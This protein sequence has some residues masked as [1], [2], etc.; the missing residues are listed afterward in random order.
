[1]S[2][3]GGA[4]INNPGVANWTGGFINAQ[5]NNVAG[6]NSTFNNL[7]GG[8]FNVQTDNTYDGY[9]SNNTA[10]DVFN[11]AGT[12][13]KSLTTGTTTMDAEFNSS[14]QVNVQTGTLALAGGGSESGSFS[15]SSGAKLNMSGTFTFTASSSVS[16]AGTAGFSSGTSTFNAGAALNPA[17]GIT[18]SGGTVQ[19]DSVQ[20]LASLTISGGSLN[21]T[22]THLFINYGTNPDPV[23]TIRGY[24]ASGYQ[25]GNWGGSGIDS[26]AA[27]HDAAYALGYADSADPGNPAQLASGTIEI[28]YTLYGDT[29]LDGSVNSIDFGNLATNFGKSGKVWD[30]ATSTTTA[31]STAS[32][33]G[34][35]PATSA[36]RPAAMP[37]WFPPPIGPLWTPS[38]RQTV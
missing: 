24:L 1:M 15:V 14:G 26:S 21:L 19:L 29:N 20:T 23:V 37:M 30:R 11:N 27:A 8:S 10:P 13:T 3:K 38:R 9:G 4:T 17:K 36:N 6:Q 18:I 7:L 16:G 35:W 31:R 32:T 22:N 5:G 28:K 34:Y 33:S 2:L 25:G 12:F